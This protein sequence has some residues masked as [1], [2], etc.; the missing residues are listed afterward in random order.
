MSEHAI[1][2]LESESG[3]STQYVLNDVSRSALKERML[4]SQLAW[5]LDIENADQVDELCSKGRTETANLVGQKQAVVLQ[6][7]DCSDAASH[8]RDDAADLR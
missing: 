1:I 5:G 6:W 2:L 8:R 3:G 7:C 4:G